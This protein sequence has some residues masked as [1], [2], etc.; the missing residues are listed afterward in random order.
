MSIIE[1]LNTNAG[2]VNAIATTVLAII[3]FCYLIVTKQIKEESEKTRKSFVE[4]AEKSRIE[5]KKPILSF[6]SDDYP[7]GDWN[8]LYLCNYGPIARNV[9]IITTC[10]LTQLSNLFLYTLGQ[11]DRISICGEWNT[12]QRERKKITVEIKF[13]DADLRQYT[14]QMSIDYNLMPNTALVV[15]PVSQP[16]RVDCYSRS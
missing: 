2:A 12:A 14:Q 11:R 7:G 13:H 16:Y 8:S 1:A 6:Q 9:S 5:E 10:E 15:I 3:T 4:E